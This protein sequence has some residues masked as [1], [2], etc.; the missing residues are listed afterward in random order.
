M[1]ANSLGKLQS[2]V[3]KL[4]KDIFIKVFDEELY[5]KLF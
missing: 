2:Q 4:P 5:N 1:K 3:I